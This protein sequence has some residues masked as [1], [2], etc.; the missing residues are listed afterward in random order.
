VQWLT[1]LAAIG[2]STILATAAFFA[3]A[4]IAAYRPDD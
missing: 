1:I 3:G 2:A 4:A